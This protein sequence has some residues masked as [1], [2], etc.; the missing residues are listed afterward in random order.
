MINRL[1]VYGT[2]APGQ[3]NDHYLKIL[4]GIWQPARVSGRL[5]A[6]GLGPTQGYPVLDVVDKQTSI[7]GLLFSSRRL[8]GIWRAL[9]Q[10]E[11]KGY[12]RCITTVVLQ[13]GDTRTAYIYA[14]AYADLPET[15]LREY[16]LSVPGET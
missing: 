1:F 14:L 12:Q 2:L 9:D 16:D 7:P 10:F 13:N 8:A 5:Y 11:G 4:P 15:V 6:K 3:A